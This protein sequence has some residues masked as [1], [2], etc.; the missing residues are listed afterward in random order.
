MCEIWSFIVEIKACLEIDK[1]IKN[2]QINLLT[3]HVLNKASVFTIGLSP[4]IL[5]SS[6]KRS[7]IA[8]LSAKVSK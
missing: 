4:I 1:I 3:N 6:E 7:K 8:V 5:I 2:W